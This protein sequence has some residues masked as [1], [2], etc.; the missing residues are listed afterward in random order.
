MVE[1]LFATLIVAVVVSVDQ[2]QVA[3]LY[4]VVASQANDIQD[5][6]VLTLALMIFG[7]YRG[8]ARAVRG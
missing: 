7:L 2:P 8:V 5:W 3:L 6:L 4:A 1:V